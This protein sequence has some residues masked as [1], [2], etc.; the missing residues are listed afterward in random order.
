MIHGNHFQVSTVDVFP[1]GKTWGPWLWYLNGGS[2]HDASAR[3]EEEFA[4]WPYPWLNDEAYQARGSVKGT[5]KLSDGRPAANAAVFLGDNTPIKA[6]LGQGSDYYYTDYADEEGRFEF[7]HVRAATYGFQAWSN[8]SEIADV[9]T[10]FLK[11]DVVVEADEATD[12]ETLEWRTSSREK[13]FQVGDFDR[14]SYGFR[15]G[16]A[17]YTHALAANCP[18]NLRYVV[19]ES[20]ADDWCFVQTYQGNWTI[21]F[22]AE[23]STPRENATLIVSLAGNT[24]GV[25]LTIWAN[26][27]KIGNLT[28]GAPQLTNDGSVYRSATTA[29]EWRYLEFPFSA[30]LLRESGN[31]ITFQVTRNTTWR[32]FM[33]DSVVLEW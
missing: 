31:E 2:K 10:S 32:G 29:G 30:S 25:S 14:T 5:L 11:N 15:Y 17:P 26:D 16:G 12:L 7:K 1:D 13:L 19:G 24:G 18:A 8:G 23:A 27:S 21:A 3:A 4:A 20:A 33:W 6:A 28:S 9:T 22:D